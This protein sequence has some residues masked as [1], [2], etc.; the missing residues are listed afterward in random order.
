MFNDLSE[1]N[2]DE[3][4]KN[5]VRLYYF[6]LGF[7]QLKIDERWR[8]HF[9]SQFLPQITEDIHN[10]RYDFSSRILKGSIVN[11]L[12][13]EK[14]GNT[15]LMVNESCNPDIAAPKL[16]KVCGVEKISMKTY[17]VG[18]RYSMKDS[19]F[20]QVFANHCIT[21]LDRTDYKKEFAQV[22]LPQGKESVCPF[23]KKV[24]ETE[25]WKIMKEMTEC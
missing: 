20:H 9:Y 2:I 1:I 15:H 11:I 8:L 5:Y 17:K 23:S 10:H 16:N 7:I 21:L 12:W 6:G 3:L 14:T 4:K 19:M 18:D 25:L 22:V 13:Q 24:D